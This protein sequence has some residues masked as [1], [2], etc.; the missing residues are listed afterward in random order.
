MVVQDAGSSVLAT[1]LIH[2]LSRRT[3]STRNQHT[4][5]GCHADGDI[6]LGCGTVLCVFSTVAVG[7]TLDLS[8]FC[9]KENNGKIDKNVVPLH[10]TFWQG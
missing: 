7:V 4:L 2:G 1:G 5:R 9:G 6:G 8:M 3:G 10:T